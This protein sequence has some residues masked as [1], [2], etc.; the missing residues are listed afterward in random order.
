MV[1]ATALPSAAASSRDLHH[2]LSVTMKKLPPSLSKDSR[3]K[4]SGSTFVG[5]S[6]RRGVILGAQGASSLAVVP[7]VGTRSATTRSIL[8]SSSRR[9][10]GAGPAE[11][12]AG[13]AALGGL[14]P[15][16]LV[17]DENGC[18]VTPRPLFTPE[19]GK[20]SRGAGVGDA[21]GGPSG[22]GGGSATDMLSSYSF[23]QTAVHTASMAGQFTRS[24]FGS[25]LSV[26]AHSSLDS[27]TDEIAEPSVQ[28]DYSSLAEVQNREEDG[29]QVLGEA[30]LN[31]TVTL[32]L[33]ETSTMEIMDMTSVS[34]STQD[35]QA[36]AIRQRNQTY[37]Q[38]CSSRVGNERY[39]ERGAQ[40]LNLQ[41]KSKEVQCDRIVTADAGIFA[42]TWDMHDTLS[43]LEASKTATGKAES[44]GQPVSSTSL[45]AS[46]R[47][48][49][50]TAITAS[51]MGTDSKRSLSSSTAQ[52]SEIAPGLVPL[53]AE[54]SSAPPSDAVLG[55][56]SFQR[57]LATMERVLVANLYQPQMAA[58]RQLPVLPDPD[59]VTEDE[60]GAP[61]EA[62]AIEG[63]ERRPRGNVGMEVG[64]KTL[65]GSSAQIPAVVHGGGPFLQRL[66][67]FSCGLTKGRNVSCLA[68]N[69]LNP[70][71]LAVG[72]GEFGIRDQKEG[73]ACGWSLKNPTWPDR[74]FHMESGVTCIDFSAAN[75]NLLAVGTLDG[76]VAVH[77]TRGGAEDVPSLTSSE[78][79]KHMGAVWQVQWVRFEQGG[80]GEDRGETLTSISADGRV[81]RWAVRKGLDCQDLMRLKRTGEGRTRRT[82]GVEG[83][84]ERKNEALIWRLA[85]GTCVDFHP[86]DSNMY[87][88]GTE[89]GF[90]HRCSCSYSEQH[91][92]SY[93][94]HQGPVYRVLWSPF[95]PEVFLSCSSDWSV[96]LWRVDLTA[97]VLTLQCG[98]QAVL[99]VAWSPHSPTLLA[100]LTAEALHVWDLSSSTLDPVLVSPGRRGVHTTRVAFSRAPGHCLLVGDSD[101]H[102]TLY[103]LKGLLQTKKVGLSDV[104]STILTSQSE[105]T[106]AMG[107]M[108]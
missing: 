19:Q 6:Q 12:R 47:F 36:E 77:N 69:R 73:L 67:A 13:G 20:A 95:E 84:R 87:L 52:G 35:S 82:A 79:G 9:S 58:Y 85:C 100:A 38:L 101:G 3:G 103:Q 15:S 42:S 106:A 24:T 102:V 63:Q 51:S 21:A 66:W 18:D 23:Y 81:T 11:G 1:T 62:K 25:S 22:G 14:R 98:S 80:G 33:S 61:E 74:V 68:W 16:M 107:E 2:H 70:D 59:G 65:H 37:K 43:E 78:S 27:L 34:V 99:D 57:D 86:Q 31:R 89:E 7:R 8:T 26:S 64:P 46:Q 71:L 91:L 5:M 41:R 96:R 108:S 55:S 94:A 49:P 56:P 45:T 29:P 17:L 30:E 97:P 10:L 72:Y 104:I 28:N 88:A 90:I 93:S 32:W 4:Q 83:Q 92:H 54:P 53:L 76:T 105:Q 44:A 40:T 39:M 50:G 75:A 60:E 48:A